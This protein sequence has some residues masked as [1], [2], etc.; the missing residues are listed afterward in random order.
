[1]ASSFLYGPTSSYTV[2]S[3]SEP[4]IVEYSLSKG[5]E[6]LGEKIKNQIQQQKMIAKKAKMVAKKGKRGKKK[7]N[8]NKPRKS[9]KVKKKKTQKKNKV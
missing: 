2:M 5:E 1:M 3:P 6:H 9:N 7:G 4:S 8:K